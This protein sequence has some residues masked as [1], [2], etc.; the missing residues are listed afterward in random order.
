MWDVVTLLKVKSFGKTDFEDQVK[1]ADTCW[2]TPKWFTIDTKLGSLCVY[3]K[4]SSFTYVFY[5][6]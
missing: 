1:R 5:S 3:V 2:N 6:I 4:T